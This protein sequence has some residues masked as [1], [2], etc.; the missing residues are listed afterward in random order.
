MS[1]GDSYSRT[2]KLEV[3]SSPLG[4]VMAASMPQVSE[5]AEELARGSRAEC[6]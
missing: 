1:L 6:R 5:A 3:T 2:G 4:E